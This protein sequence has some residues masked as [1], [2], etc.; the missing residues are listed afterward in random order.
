[1]NRLISLIRRFS[2]CNEGLLLRLREK[3]AASTPYLSEVNNYYLDG[4]KMLRPA[5]LLQLAG[6][7]E[8]HSG[9]PSAEL[10]S[11]VRPSQRR[12]AAIVEMIHAASLLH[13]DVVDE[14]SVRRGKQA[15]NVRF[16]AKS[17]V[18]SGDYLLAQASVNLAELGNIQVITLLATVIKDLVEGEILQ[19]NATISEQLSMEYYLRKSYL[20]TASLIAKSCQATA[21]LGAHPEPIC[22]ACYQFGRHLGLAFQIIDDRLDYS[23]STVELGKPVGADL[24]NGIVTAPVL[25]AIE[26]YPEIRDIIGR[27]FSRDDD[28][29]RAVM[30]TVTSDGLQRTQQLADELLNKS[31]AALSFLPPSLLSDS[32][33]ELIASVT[34][35]RK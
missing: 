4:G 28:Y 16:G 6:A 30:L 34:T 35:R 3:V 29:D 14:A 27:N 2:T 21:A 5:I 32:F 25:F 19:M 15:A 17:A 13:D 23:A 10:E 7:L 33:S 31:L 12:L 20:K 26:Q 18:L 24:M 22:S 8:R 9:T 1:M 11:G